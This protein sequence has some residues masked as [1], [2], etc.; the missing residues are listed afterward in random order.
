MEETRLEHLP[1]DCISHVLSFTCPRDV[2]HSSLVSSGIRDACE[3]DA[4]WENFL[5][6]NYKEII[7]RLV[8]PMVFTSK[9]ELFHKLCSP[10]L[11]DEGKKVN[12]SNVFAHS[13]IFFH[14]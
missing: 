13:C 8:S 12:F 14:R 5:P 3:S 2:R 1:Q 4:L 7:S 6:S 10:L 11:V 9:K